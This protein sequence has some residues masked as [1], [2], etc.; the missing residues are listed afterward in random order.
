MSSLVRVGNYV[1]N[2]G[3]GCHR[4]GGTRCRLSCWLQWGGIATVN[5]TPRDNR[6]EHCRLTVDRWWKK[7]SVR[8]PTKCSAEFECRISKSTGR[9][10][11][12]GVDRRKE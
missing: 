3:D 10:P 12:R 6:V 8:S 5:F 9:L 1:E 2:K 4:R 11:L 7:D